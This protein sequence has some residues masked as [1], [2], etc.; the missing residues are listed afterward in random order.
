MK[1][2]LRRLLALCLCVAI[3]FGFI[4]TIAPVTKADA[5]MYTSYTTI[6]RVPTQ[7][8]C[9]GMQGMDVDGTYIYCAK[10]DDDTTATIAR[11]H[12][13]TGDLT[14]LTNYSTGTKYFSNLYHAN[15]LT[16]CTIDGVKTMFVGTGGAG[17]GDYSLV[18]L[19]FDGTTLK[20]V[21]HY[22]LQYNGTSKYIAGVKVVAVNSTEVTL[23]LKSGNYVFAGK[24][25][26]KSTSGNIAID[27]LGKL[28]FSAVNFNGT[29]RDLSDY[30]VQGFGY[31][32]NKLFVP[33][34]ANH[35]DSTSHIST[36]VC[37]D[38]DGVKGG[39]LKP[40]PNMSVWIADSTP[41]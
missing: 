39:N 40:D 41:L 35:Q 36:I 19:V 23:V 11:V 21:G 29:V 8:P 38:I 13:D 9:S 25:P 37:F 22:N 16:V 34:T 17:A 12:K 7:S 18:R 1:Q 24:I 3:V 26:V 15:D 4:P 30:V 2:Y 6:A 32:D 31:K 27:Y 28:D 20:M 5:A 33:M 14:W 10:I